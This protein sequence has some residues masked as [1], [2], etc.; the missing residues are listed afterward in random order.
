MDE[1]IKSDLFRY[2][3]KVSFTTAL[4]QFL[5]NRAFRVQVFIRASNRGGGIRQNCEVFLLHESLL[6]PEYTN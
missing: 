2:T 1:Y 6:L 3:G 5:V 4:K